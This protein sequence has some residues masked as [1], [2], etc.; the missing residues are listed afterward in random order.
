MLGHMFTIFGSSAQAAMLDYVI[1]NIAERHLCTRNCKC[2]K[3]AW[4]LGEGMY[5]YL[6]LSVSLRSQE[7]GLVS[8]TCSMTVQEV[9]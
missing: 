5:V 4:E 1:D 8:I 7:L 9:V 3:L 2:Q 6:W